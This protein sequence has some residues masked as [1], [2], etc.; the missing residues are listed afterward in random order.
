MITYQVGEDVGTFAAA[1]AERLAAVLPNLLVA[2]IL[3]AAGWALAGW[4]E[5]GAGR[6]LDRAQIEPTLRGVTTGV[7]RYGLLVIVV[8]AVLGQLGIQMTSVLAA[9]GAIALAIGLALQGTLANIAAGIMLLWL[10]P[11]RVGDYIE[12][13]SVAGTVKDVGLFAS[14]LHSGDGLYQFVPNSELWNKRIIN[15]SRLDRRLVDLKFSISYSDDADRG[16][17]VLLSLAERDDRVLADPPPECFV[18]QL[19]ENAV[20]LAL[21]GWTGTSAYW[22]VR[23]MLTERGKVALEAA[24]LSIP[25]PQR[26]IR[27]MSEKE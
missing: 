6:L 7:V 25:L 1:L 16:R 14:E 24:G 13:G 19:G 26:V 2:L 5:R 12:A 22:P 11:F 23:R 18:D 20:V 9:L 21:R 3:L 27:K 10:R 15:Y 8:V 4:A 17:E